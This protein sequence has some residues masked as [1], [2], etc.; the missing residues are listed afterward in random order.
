MS[1]PSVLSIEVHY[2]IYCPERVLDSNNHNT[3]VEKKHLR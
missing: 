2:K 1:Y 3:N